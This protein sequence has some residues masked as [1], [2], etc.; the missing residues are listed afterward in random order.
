MKIMLLSD[1]HGFLNPKIVEIAKNVDEIWHAGDIGNIQ[2][3]NT[4]ASLKPFKAVWGNIDDLEIKSKYPKYS[5][6]ETEGVRVLMIHIAGKFE[7]YNRETKNL[8]E[9]YKPTILACGHSHILKV[10]FDK[11]N[12]LLY[13]NPGA[14]GKQGFHLF[15]TLLLFEIKE[16]NPT[17]LNVIELGKR[18]EII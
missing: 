3:C 6:F 17:N 15:M 8:I 9:E 18:I 16:G 4:L 12:N 10:A 5:T 14:A 13:M 1:T 7:N 2:I 11:K